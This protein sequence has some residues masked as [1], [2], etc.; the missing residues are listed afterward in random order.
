MT[1]DSTDS[2]IRYVVVVHGMGEPKQHSTLACV[3]SRLAEARRPRP[4]PDGTE[5]A[6]D[7]IVPL[8]RLTGE[9]GA[10]F[11]EGGEYLDP[12]PGS[13]PWMEFAG[14]PTCPPDGDLNDAFIAKPLRDGE[15]ENLRF[16]S[17]DWFDISRSSFEQV[18]EPVVRW[19]SGLAQR[20]HGNAKAASWAHLFLEKLSETLSVAA[21]IT[22]HRAAETHEL[23]FDRYLG[24]VQTYAE[25]S[26]CRGRAI[27]RFHETLAAVKEKHVALHGDQPARFTVLA[28]SLG[29]VLAWE[30]L[31]RAHA[32]P[33]LWESD[34]VG[35]ESEWLPAY[36]RA[37]RDLPDLSWIDD[38]DAST[39]SP[40]SRR[41][42]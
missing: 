1:D 31:L 28:H 5:R 24:D 25:F 13:R 19:S 20:L 14:I 18:G 30:S 17:V 4:D 3:I 6:V 41:A 26:E 35:F 2:A 36:R 21:P 22:K 38:V 37:G 29:S 27:R 40:R 15:G 12:E 42:G 10:R 11:S 34:G 7:T 9:T 23:I 32:K 16:V 33:E 8:G 39:S